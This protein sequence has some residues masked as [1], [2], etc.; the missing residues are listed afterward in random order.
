M[1][2]YLWLLLAM[3]AFIAL[4]AI[5]LRV[6]S[7]TARGR[8]FLALSTRGKL[9]FGRTLLADAD[10]PLAAKI[11]LVVLVGYLALP[12]DIIPDFIPVAGQLD[13]LAVVV[14]TV[15]LLI[16]VIPRRRFESALD[17]AERAEEA[18][19]EKIE[20]KTNRS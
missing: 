1:A 13:D 3:G 10:V 4:A 11:M 17:E 15:A 6:L 9:R 16:V 2:W 20:P 19:R 12:F 14:M 5:T 8:R 7:L 18:R